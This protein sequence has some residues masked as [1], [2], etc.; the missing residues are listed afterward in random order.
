MAKHAKMSEEE[1]NSK[2]TSSV[3]R[4]T[5][6]SNT[7]KKKNKKN[8]KNRKVLKIVLFI[9]VMALIIFA[10]IFGYRVY[11]NGGGMS[12]FLATMVGHD[13]NTKKS[14]A[15][16]QFLLIGESGNMTDTIMICSYNPNTQQ[17]SLLSIPRDTYIG[18]NLK[19]VTASDKINS[20]YNRYKD[21]QKT[22]D[23][24][25][26]LTGLN[27]QYYVFVDTN[28]LK[29]L[30]DAI[31]GVEFD[32][33]IKM[34]YDDT[35]KENYIRIHIDKG[36]QTIKGDKVEGLLRFRHNND[37]TTYPPEYGEEDIGR[38]RTQREFISA[39]LKQT[40]KPGNI[41]K[42]GQILDIANKNVKTN[43]PLNLA[44]DYLPYAVEFST[45][46]LRTEMLPGTPTNDY[47]GVWI[48]LMDDH[49]GQILISNLFF[50]GNY[51]TENKDQTDTRPT[52]QV[53]NGS[54]KEEN[55]AKAVK[56]LQE[57]GYRIIK[58]GNTITTKKTNI[59]NRTKQDNEIV[60]DIKTTL[61][62]GSISSG[63]N[64]Q[65]VDITIT[66]GKDYE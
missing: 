54:G 30:V 4:K 51:D 14:L 24:V 42:L 17:A 12:G 31:G 62:I 61:G 36:L 10:G 49:N 39:T 28:A 26:E 25:N 16:I 29:E 23:E 63:K 19:K 15:E 64:N 35:S 58:V 65:K 5:S 38:M 66:L 11:K 2:K 46:N 53:L 18:E 59:I 20:V 50:G 7:Q 37:R 40:L 1:E 55:L 6:S 21:P 27:L 13:E 8:K 44:K 48:Y 32:V 41:F 33:P 47:N 56:Q 43:I 3:N 22:V 45:E 60:T 9:I 52:I 34:D 57:K